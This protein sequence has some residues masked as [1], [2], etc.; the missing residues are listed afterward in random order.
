M[1]DKGRVNQLT[2][3]THFVLKFLG[4]LSLEDL[5][6][7]PNWVGREEKVCGPGHSY[8]KDTLKPRYGDV[9]AIGS[10]LPCREDK[11]VFTGNISS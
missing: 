6:I 8:F 3:F 1:Y 9:H 4:K 11:S 10:R 5:S 7:V 2:N